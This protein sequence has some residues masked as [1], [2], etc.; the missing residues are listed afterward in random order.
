MEDFQ[1]PEEVGRVEPV[2]SNPASAREEGLSPSVKKSCEEKEKGATSM[3]VEMASQHRFFF[4]PPNR[5]LAFFLLT[6]R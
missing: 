1:S 2:P 3:E 5:R 6:H 4:E